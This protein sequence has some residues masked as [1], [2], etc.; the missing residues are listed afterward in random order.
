LR[1]NKSALEIGPQK[2]VIVLSQGYAKYFASV[3]SAAREAGFQPNTPMIDLSGQSPGLLYS[4]GA[5][6]V[7]QAWTIGG[8]PGSLKLAEAALAQTSCKKISAAWVLF[9]QAGPRSIP[10]ELMLSVG[11]DFPSSYRHVGTWQTAEGA[12]GYPDRRTQDLY[13]PLEQHK[14]L[15]NC[16]KLREEAGQ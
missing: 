8:Y 7:G 3:E 6:S 12:G 5:E 11:A 4:I 1:L 16:Q 9:E 14:T 15:M 2:S 13:R 10:T